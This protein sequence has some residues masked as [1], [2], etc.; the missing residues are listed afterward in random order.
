[1]EFFLFVRQVLVVVLTV[2]FFWPLTIPLAALAYKI[3]SGQRPIALE[4]AAFWTRATFA[5]LGLCLL[6]VAIMANDRF[7]VEY[8]ELPAGIVHLVMLTVF[9]AIAVWYV[10]WM[11]ALDELLDGVGLLMIFLFLPGLPL[12][13]LSALF[14][15]PLEPMASWISSN[16][17]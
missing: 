4:P 5:A 15:F 2:S 1:V 17:T 9:I 3:R 13:G 16:I 12:L 7:L 14:G 6:A 8:A 10:F 11:F